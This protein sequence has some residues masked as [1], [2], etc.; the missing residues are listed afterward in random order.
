[1]EMR[2]CH[3][4]STNFD[5]IYYSYL[6]RGIT[7]KGAKQFFVSLG[8]PL[9]PKWME[10]CSSV[11]YSSL[12]I[13]SRLFYPLAVWRLSRFLRKNKIDILHTHLFDAAI[14]G[15]VAA[16]VARTPKKVVS[17]HHLDEAAI[18]GTRLHVALDKWSNE[19]ADCVVVPSNATKRFMIEY[20]RQSAHNIRIVPYGFDFDVMH[21]DNAD[22]NRIRKEFGL[23]NNFVLGSVGRFFKNKGHLFLLEAFSKVVDDCPSVRL[24]LLGSGDRVPIENLIS[25]LNIEEY[26]IFAGYRNDVPACMKAMDILVHPSLSESFGQVIVEAMS[27]GTPVIVTSVGGVPEIVTNGDTGIVVQPSNSTELYNAIITLIRDPTAHARLGL[28]GK[29]SVLRKYNVRNFVDRQWECYREL[30]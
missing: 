7:E 13:S 1:M 27:V 2:I 3:F 20:E 19:T 6:G 26:V 18:L 21:A 11:E 12:G 8:D 15:L 5:G 29:E 30:C 10:D 14:I 22:R 16:K 23:V 4:C 28:R 9:P 17:R 24:L 25:K